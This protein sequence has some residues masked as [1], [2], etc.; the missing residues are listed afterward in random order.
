M[1]INPEDLIRQATAAKMRGVSPQAISRLI[2]RGS[3]RTV[4]IDGLVFVYRE[5]V[6]N[7]TPS[8]GGRPQSKTHP[9]KSN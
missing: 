5:E 3:L 1:K 6:E 2:A 7:F 9:K 4:V 8:K